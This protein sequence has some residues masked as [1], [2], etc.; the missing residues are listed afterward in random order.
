LSREEVGSDGVDVCMLKNK[1]DGIGYST[2]I[3]AP[4][5]GQWSVF[6]HAICEPATPIL[7]YCS[8]QDTLPNLLPRDPFSFDAS[9][10]LNVLF[11]FFLIDIY[12][13]CA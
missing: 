8:V 9:T 10:K 3:S 13:T 5:D 6:H 12:S 11:E 7:K 2:L 4:L 1:A